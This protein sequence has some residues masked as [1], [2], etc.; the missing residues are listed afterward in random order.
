MTQ[1]EWA[2]RVAAI[3]AL[4]KWPSRWIRQLDQP[5]TA[6][7]AMA[8]ALPEEADPAVVLAIR[9][10]LADWLA[11]EG[12]VASRWRTGTPGKTGPYWCELKP[13]RAPR[14]LDWNGEAWL[15]FSNRGL[16]AYHADEIVRWQKLDGINYEVSHE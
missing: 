11:S 10:L 7:A 12:V 13:G 3:G 8:C 9:Q 16:Q 6:F 14:Q 1:A 5:R 4:A 2:A 15:G